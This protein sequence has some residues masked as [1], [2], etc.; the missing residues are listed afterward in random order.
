MVDAKEIVI[1]NGDGEHILISRSRQR[2]QLRRTTERTLSAPA[3][4]GT[5][6]RRG[7]FL[8]TKSGRGWGVLL[9][10]VRLKVHRQ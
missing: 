8:R 7:S 9:S 4:R 1:G 5:A 2:G 3:V 10:L 6:F